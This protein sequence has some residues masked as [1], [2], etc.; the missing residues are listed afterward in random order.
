MSIRSETNRKIRADK[1]NPWVRQRDWL[2]IPDVTETD[3]KFV[4]LLAIFNNINND[5]AL[6][7]SGN[8][9][10][11]WGDGNIE[12]YNAGVTA[13][14]SFNFNNV[15]LANT[16]TSKGYKQCI[17][18]VTPQAGEQ[19]TALDICILAPYGNTS[20]GY[21][22]GWLDINLG[23]PNFSSSGL[24]LN[25]LNP[26]LRH[27]YL[28][29]IKVANFGNVTDGYYMFAECFFLQKI[30][31][32]STSK[33]TTFSNFFY[34]CRNLLKVK[35]FD[36][37]NATDLSGLFYLAA[38]LTDIPALNTSKCLNFSNMFRNLTVATELPWIDTSKGTNFS[39]MYSACSL[40]KAIPVIDT[41]NGTD[42]SSFVQASNNL[43]T[44]P[45]IDTSKAVT[46]ASMFTLVQKL[47][48][49]PELN[50]G[51]CTNFSNMF[52][53]SPSF[54]KAKF[55]GTNASIS[56]SNMSLSKIALEDIFSGLA[57]N[58]TTKTITI[59]PNYG[60]DTAVTKSSVLTS[61]NPVVNVADTSNLSVGMLVTGTGVNTAVA[62]TLQTT[63]NTITRA[64]HG[65]ANDTPISFPTIVT[66][67]GLTVYTK[68]FVVNATPNTFQV[69]LTAGGTPL[70]L[71]N[72]G[73]G[74]LLYGSFITNITPNINVTLSAPVSVTGTQTLSYRL[75]NTSIATIKGWTVS[76]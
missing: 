39:W 42:F 20:S 38:K 29:R 17:V 71:T 3:E 68:Y 45:M 55:I 19:L 65:L 70:V 16:L 6:S 62:V 15:L 61:G 32:A 13:Y 25:K 47:R 63:A 64:N 67:T 2:T 60:A 37:S 21:T 59:N 4:G 27:M 72:N 35:W 31:L 5:Y 40:L 26:F 18:I 51:A 7:A 41:S 66:T 75:L 53:A 11:D 10:V 48:V 8:Y 1:D 69:A 49:L 73:T 24:K 57:N 33:F 34:N 30:I 14:H 50:V 44:F 52:Q 22:T 43:Q 36:T 28:E 9:T 54:Q 56:Y 46:M 74:T 58:G 23:S 76:G 12:N